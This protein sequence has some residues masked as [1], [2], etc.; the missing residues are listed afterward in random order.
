MDNLNKLLLSFSKGLGFREDK[1]NDNLTDDNCAEW[2]SV[3]QVSIIANIEDDF[4]IKLKFEDFL[5]INSFKTA[6][7]ILNNYN[8]NF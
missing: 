6:K 5:K 1:I 2:T 7:E 4:G 3:S 8:I